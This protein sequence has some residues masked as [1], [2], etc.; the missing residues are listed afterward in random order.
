M[1]IKQ[2]TRLSKIRFAI[3]GG[4]CMAIASPAA[5]LSA[6]TKAFLV[7]VGI[8][9]ESPSVKIADADGEIHTTFSVEIPKYSASR[10]WLRTSAPM[11]CASS[12]SPG[13]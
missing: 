4:V 7:S 1:A 6:Q 13:R 12:F 3:L 11:R 2:T 10:S 8:D 5:A 9:P